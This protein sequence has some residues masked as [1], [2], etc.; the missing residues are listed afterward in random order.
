M[1][2]PP[3]FFNADA[4]DNS[5]AEN[6][7]PLPIFQSALKKARS[8]LKEKFEQGEDTRQL[9]F[10]HTAIIDQLLSRAYSLFVKHK[11]VALIA[12]GGYGRGELHPAS[13]TDILILLPTI[14]PLSTD[15][16]STDKEPTNQEATHEAVEFLLTFLWDLGMQVGH[17][18]R[19][20]EDC[21]AEAQQDITVITNLVES[22]LICGPPD[23]FNK[24]QHAIAPEYIWPS[25]DF[26]EAKLKEQAARHHKFFDTGY[27]LEPNVKEG[28]GGLRDIH[29][30]GW[31]A[32]RHFGSATLH[33]L[34]EKNFLT[35]S[36]YNSLMTEQ[37]F[38]WK[39]R[40]GL[41]LLSGR[42]EDRLLF[43]HQRS[44]AQLFGYKD[45]EHRLA[46]EHFMKQ[47]YRTVMNISRLNEMLLLLFQ[48]AILHTENNEKQIGRASGRE[49]V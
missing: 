15:R 13:D 11:D 8:V 19:T 39:V 27:N 46:V 47:Y 29:T 37:D 41:H 2:V 6:K 23:L 45:D 30:I 31:V 26:F 12:V 42:H 44:L 21:I 14:D 34:V 1:Q 32:K 3:E 17:S 10:Q 24:M 25:C 20:I 36:E 40:F 48:E 49:R 22:R 18:V 4:F 28:P 9:V 16:K 35:T 38:I 7:P 43:D 5:L 33:E